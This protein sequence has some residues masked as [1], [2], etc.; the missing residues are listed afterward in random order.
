MHQIIYP[1]DSFKLGFLIFKD[2][3]QWIISIFKRS[4]LAIEMKDFFADFSKGLIIIQLA[5]V[6]G[7]SIFFS[8]AFFV[9]FY[10]LYIDLLMLP[11]KVLHYFFHSAK[12]T[13]DFIS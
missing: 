2:V 10:Q 4:W 5:Q 7:K 11:I 9:N 13:A 12:E 1:E 3:S 6:L 8:I